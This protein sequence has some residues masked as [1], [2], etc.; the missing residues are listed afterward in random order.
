MLLA[1][2]LDGRL[3]RHEKLRPIPLPEQDWLLP[4]SRISHVVCG[5]DALPA[6]IVAPDPRWF[7]LHKLWLADKPSRNPL[8]KGKDRAQ[9]VQVLD[10][11]AA[12]MPHY[13]LDEAFART[14]PKEL[15]GYF[16]RW[17]ES[18]KT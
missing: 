5:F 3:P 6:R 10:M 4:G 17:I 7:A 9:G 18:R 2:S 1:K 16:E 11:V 15:T 12:H 8:K 14:L 13:S